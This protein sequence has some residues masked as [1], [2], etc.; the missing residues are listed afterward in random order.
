M[1]K[2]LLTAIVYLCFT[3]SVLAQGKDDLSAVKLIYTVYSMSGNDGAVSESVKSGS[4]VPSSV[5]L[6]QQEI[7]DCIS[8]FKK[9]ITA[10]LENYTP[11]TIINGQQEPSRYQIK[12]TSP[13]PDC[14]NIKETTFKGNWN[15]VKNQKEENILIQDIQKI[16]KENN[17]PLQF[18]EFVYNILINYKEG[19]SAPAKVNG[20]VVINIPSKL[21]IVTLTN[22]DINKEYTVGN[23]KVKLLEIKGS[24]YKLEMSGE[25]TSVKIL[26][27]NDKSL[28]FS[29]NM[30]RNIPL[31]FYREFTKK[32]ELTDADLAEALKT[33]DKNDKWFVRLGS[34]SGT[35]NKILIYSPEEIA[36]RT[37]EIDLEINN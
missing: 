6:K 33:Y 10:S 34:V 21:T 24:A 12:L 20:T 15:F 16:D 25:D 5:P 2:N 14:P 28:E 31:H 23:T 7:D 13:L 22:K 32:K 36:T 18:R 8:T 3:G 30:G 19:D 1:K 29:M 26:P 11:T 27:L 35:I 17:S 4:G 37:I 9:S